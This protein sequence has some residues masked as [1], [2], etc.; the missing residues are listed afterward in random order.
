MDE[1]EKF[2]CGGVEDCARDIAANVRDRPIFRSSLAGRGS[3]LFLL[4]R[5]S[6]CLGEDDPRW[7]LSAR[8]ILLLL[9]LLVLART[10]LVVAGRFALAA[11][12]AQR[13]FR[14][15]NI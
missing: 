11:R 8:I 7:A 10:L 1:A 2:A 4:L 14:G 6:G 13:R 5:R 15:V 9:L 3:S 12:V